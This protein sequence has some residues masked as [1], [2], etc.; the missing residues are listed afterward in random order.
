MTRYGL[1]CL[2]SIRYAVPLL[3]LRK[4]VPASQSYLLPR[5]P[6]AVAEVLVDEGQLVP[7]LTLPFL[8]ENGALISRGAEYRVIAESEGG[9]VAFSAEITCGI[10]AESKGELLVSEEQLRPWTIGLFSYKGEEFTILDID[11][12]AI[13]MTQG[14]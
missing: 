14:V 12:L 3:R 5:L 1:F 11:F 2:G 4:I 7:L 9:L 6:A 8:P 10:I 13:E